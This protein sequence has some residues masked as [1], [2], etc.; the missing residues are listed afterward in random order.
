MPP[1][2]FTCRH[3]TIILP[4]AREVWDSAAAS[5]KSCGCRTAF[6]WGLG[7]R[8]L[9]Y[10]QQQTGMRIAGMDVL[11]ARKPESTES[12]Q[13]QEGNASP[14]GLR[15][16]R[17]LVATHELASSRFVASG[18]GVYPEHAAWRS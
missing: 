10:L 8:S 9:G 1:R 15:Q 17:V 5:R 14:G 7:K 12:G 4:R 2:E 13:G 11:L 18:A 16:T 6:C 3:G